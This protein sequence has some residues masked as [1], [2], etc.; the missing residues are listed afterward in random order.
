MSIVVRE[1]APGEYGAIADLTVDAYREFRA[2]IGPELWEA[3]ELDLRAVPE[4]AREAVILVAEEASS[5]VGAAAYY[6]PGYRQMQW[7]PKEHAWLRVLAVSPAQRGRGIGRMLTE[8][9]IRRARS[10]GAS[11]LGLHTTHLMTTARAMYEQMGF[12]VEEEFETDG[13]IKVWQYLLP[14]GGR[15]ADS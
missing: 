6:R 5:L 12:Q 11:G 4:R 13:G 7:F 1:A 3:Y 10:E 14:L 2:A 9:C 15:S 8:E